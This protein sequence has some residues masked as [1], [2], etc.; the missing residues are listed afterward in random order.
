[1]WAYVS[2]AILVGK[3]DSGQAWRQ[4]QLR[5]HISNHRQEAESKLGMVALQTLTAQC[6]WHTPSS[7]A[8]PLKHPQTARPTS[9]QAVKT[10]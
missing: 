8:T 1:M 3:H 10:I 5:V 6:Q 7:K 2:N 4:E 9:S